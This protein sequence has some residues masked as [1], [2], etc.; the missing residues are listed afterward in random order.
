VGFHLRRH[1]RRRTARGCFRAGCGGSGGR[2]RGGTFRRRLPRAQGH[3]DLPVQ[4]RLPPRGT[5]GAA[6]GTC[7][8]RGGASEAF[9]G[10]VAALRNGGQ[11]PMDPCVGGAELTIFDTWPVTGLHRGVSGGFLWTTTRQSLWASARMQSE[12]QKCEAQQ[13]NKSYLGIN[14]RRSVAVKRRAGDNGYFMEYRI[15]H[16]CWF[17]VCGNCPL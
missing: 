8:A 1:P 13:K 4:P 15:I 2:S 16:R 14:S 9:S 3:L 6:P 17:G 10:L 5:S 11:S 7:L 12:S